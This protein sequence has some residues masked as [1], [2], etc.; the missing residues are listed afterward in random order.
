M[1]FKKRTDGNID[2]W[3]DEGNHC[4]NFQHPD[5][6]HPFSAEYTQWLSEGNTP[7]FSE[8]ESLKQKKANLIFHRKQYRK[9]MLE[10]WW[11][12]ASSWSPPFI[13]KGEENNP[14]K[15]TYLEKVWNEEYEKMCMESAE[16]FN[17]EEYSKANI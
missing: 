16:E 5:D 7:E 9:Q 17:P 4:G 6:G 12:L 8:K 2:K 3:D 15:G 11:E 1:I 10:E 14:F 13:D